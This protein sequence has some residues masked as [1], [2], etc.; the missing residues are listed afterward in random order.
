MSDTKKYQFQTDESEAWVRPRTACSPFSIPQLL[1]G[2][3]P[4]TTDTMDPFFRHQVALYSNFSVLILVV[5]VL[6]LQGL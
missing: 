2:R 3:L 5:V 1:R 6:N 4:K